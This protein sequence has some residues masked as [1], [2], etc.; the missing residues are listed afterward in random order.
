LVS[1]LLFEFV[2]GC[3]AHVDTCVRA[4]LV[5]CYLG[6]FFDDSKRNIF[7]AFTRAR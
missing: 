1:Q 3:S 2:E 4:V 6:C 7:I 5:R